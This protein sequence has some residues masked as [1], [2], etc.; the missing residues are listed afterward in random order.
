METWQ[1]VLTVISA[2]LASNGLWAYII[3]RFDYD[4]AESK[5]LIVLSHDRIHDLGM[6]H[7][8]LKRITRDEYENLFDYLYTPYKDIGGNG[9]ADRIMVEV[10][11]LPI[12]STRS[13]KELKED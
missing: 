13:T 1:V 6:K 8:E 10:A 2:V 12:C 5:M 9:S 4:S 7:I 3:K 11:K